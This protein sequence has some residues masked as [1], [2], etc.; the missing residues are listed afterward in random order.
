MA[1]SSPM[2]LLI[3]TKSVMTWTASA[4]VGTE[5]K[6]SSTRVD[7]ITASAALGIVAL[8][9]S[10][11][12]WVTQIA[13]VGL[14][15]F[16]KT[17]PL[18]WKYRSFRRDCSFQWSFW[19]QMNLEYFLYSS[20]TCI[21]KN[22]FEMSPVKATS[23]FLYRN[24]TCVKSFMRHGPQWKQWSFMDFPLIHGAFPSITGRTGVVSELGFMT[25]K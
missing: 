12:F 11:F 19:T 17:W 16:P 20:G 24:S 8:C 14:H 23:C 4:T 13:Q 6:V 21:L 18:N 3:A 10:A 5:S 7:F 2:C 9:S 22:I 15:T 25:G 1:I